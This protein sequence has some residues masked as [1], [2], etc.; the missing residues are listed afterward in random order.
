MCSNISNFTSE[1]SKTKFYDEIADKG[2][3]KTLY[4]KDWWST[5]KTA[6][7][8]N[9]TTPIQFFSLMVLYIYNG[10]DKA[11]APNNFFQS[12]TSL[13]HLVDFF[14]QL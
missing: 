10:R 1:V 8:L 13:P 5:L 11:N 12:Q 4:A 9:S 3:S 2:R 6:I 7:S 14:K